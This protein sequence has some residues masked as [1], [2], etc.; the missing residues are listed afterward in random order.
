MS[1]ASV[2]QLQKRVV[3]TGRHI[4]GRLIFAYQGNV[5]K[6]PAQL[7]G[8]VEGI[9]GGNDERAAVVQFHTEGVSWRAVDGSSSFTFAIGD[10]VVGLAPLSASMLRAIRSLFRSNSIR[11]IAIVAK[12]S[13][14][15]ALD[16]PASPAAG[17][18][19][20][21]LDHAHGVVVPI[22][23]TQAQVEY[24][25][26]GLKRQGLQVST[27]HFDFLPSAGGSQQRHGSAKSSRVVVDL[28]GTSLASAT[29]IGRTLP[30]SQTGTV[31][32]VEVVI[33]A[34]DGVGLEHSSVGLRGDARSL[35]HDP[36]EALGDAICYLALQTE[37][38][39]T[40]TLLRALSLG[41]LP[42]VAPDPALI[43]LTKGLAEIAKSPADLVNRLGEVRPRSGLP[44]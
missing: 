20:A 6:L 30:V 14:L 1:R 35:G 31:P 21:T 38:G 5:E 17:R 26:H 41:V 27:I 8:L 34:D 11:F 15:A 18:L 40:P 2:R 42:I 36:I 37:N 16:D 12:D 43:E 4:S 10:A 28:R 25:L 23:A 9:A 29:K 32:D 33:L 7:A 44:P 39:W 24:R 13:G 19:L 3:D 22:S